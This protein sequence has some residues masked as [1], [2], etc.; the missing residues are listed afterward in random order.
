MVQVAD[1]KPK[2]VKRILTDEFTA[3]SGSTPSSNDAPPSKI[4]ARKLQDFGGDGQE[5][6]KNDGEIPE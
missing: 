1:S 3:A 4:F 2:A 5:Q 6:S